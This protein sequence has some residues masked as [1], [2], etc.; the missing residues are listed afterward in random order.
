M[1]HKVEDEWSDSEIDKCLNAMFDDC[2]E[3]I[4][5]RQRYCGSEKLTEDPLS[6]RTFQA[7]CDWFLDLMKGSLLV[8]A[9]FYM[10]DD[11]GSPSVTGDFREHDSTARFVSVACSGLPS[12]VTRAIEQGELT[13]FIDDLTESSICVT[14]KQPVIMQ[15][16]SNRKLPE[17]M[18]D[19]GAFSVYSVYNNCGSQLGRE[20]RTYIDFPV[21]VNGKVF[22]KFSCDLCTTDLSLVAETDIIHWWTTAQK[23]GVGVSVGIDM[24]EEEVIQKAA[25]CPFEGSV[26]LFAVKKQLCSLLGSDTLEL[27]RFRGM[28]SSCNDKK[29]EV[30][31]YV[32]GTSVESLSHLVRNGVAYNNQC[33]LVTAVGRFQRAFRFVEISNPSYRDG[34]ECYY[35]VPIDWEND[36]VFG[37]WGNP[38]SVVAVPVFDSKRELICVYVLTKQAEPETCG[39]SFLDEQK[40]G[41][42]LQHYTAAITDA[43]LNSRGSQLVECFEHEIECAHDP[44]EKVIELLSEYCNGSSRQFYAIYGVQESKS[45]S[46][47]F[48]FRSDGELSDPGLTSQLSLPGTIVLDAT[49]GIERWTYRSCPRDNESNLGA[50]ANGAVCE[51]AVAFKIGSGADIGII[52]IKSDCFD[53]EESSDVLKNLAKCL[54]ANLIARGIESAEPLLKEAVAICS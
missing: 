3:S 25:G 1:L 42:F 19:V 10:F 14:E 8:N 39:F 44:L 46:S 53:I 31:W 18:G 12:S 45:G 50:I 9:R 11:D 28:P 49:R 51:G 17:K 24:L 15:V 41:L 43:A 37:D 35:G 20:R 29:L 16:G 30:K 21:F 54:S 27:T 22:G 52:V 7:A 47:L 5:M 26:D 2:L 23:L 48:L 40:A 33:P 6:C 32:D 36:P 13:R 38:D 4:A 34:Y